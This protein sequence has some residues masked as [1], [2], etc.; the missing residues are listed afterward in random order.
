MKIYVHNA[1][2]HEFKAR[3]LQQKQNNNKRNMKSAF[4]V[5]DY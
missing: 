4:Y 1:Y 3:R 2:K 5:L